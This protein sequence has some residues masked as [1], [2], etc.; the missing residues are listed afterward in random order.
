[1]HDQ[2]K[3]LVNYDSHNSKYRTFEKTNHQVSEKCDVFIVCVKMSQVLL[4]IIE[5][6]NQTGPAI[7][8]E[9]TSHQNVPV[10]HE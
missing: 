2:V 6:E 5:A 8:E 7:E 9:R 10:H 3:S 4:I 1:M